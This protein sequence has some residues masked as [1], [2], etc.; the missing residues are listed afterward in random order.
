[1]DTDGLARLLDEQDGVVARRQVLAL[2][3][4]D[5]DIERLV[6]RRDL[7]PLHAGTYV[8]HTGPPTWRQRARAAVLHH[9]PAALSG[10]SALRWAGVPGVGDGPVELVVP[11]ARTVVPAP[12]VAV[13]RIAAYP[14]WVLDG[15]APPRVVI[16]HAVLDLA[17]RAPGEDAAVARLGDACQTRR[18][19]PARLLAAVDALPRLP[20]RRFLLLVLD[21]VATGAY[22]A[23]ERRYLARVE[24]AHGLPTGRRQRR[25]RSG[26]TT[27]YRDVDYLGLATVVELDGRLGHEATTDRWAD[28]DRDLATAVAGSLTVRIGWQQVLDPCRLALHLGAL[29]RAR[30]WDGTAR[31]CGPDCVVGR[32]Q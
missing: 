12:G 5:N 2:G 30:G 9:Q 24:R 27:A 17:S 16:E 31:P 6:R 11:R 4:T 22:S 13:R 32:R 26:R 14:T 28:L 15:L 23:L 20:R 19:T 25:V 8:D 18:T 29:L 10:G 21:D 3:G 7:A 1:M